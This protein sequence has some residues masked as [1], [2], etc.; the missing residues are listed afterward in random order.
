MRQECAEM[1]ILLDLIPMEGKGGEGSRIGQ[2][3]VG[4]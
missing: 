3:E 2:E 1:Q 4:S